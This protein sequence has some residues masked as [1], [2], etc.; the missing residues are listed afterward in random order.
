MH[1]SKLFATDLI[2]QRGLVLS[3]VVDEGRESIP[4]YKLL[5]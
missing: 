4:Y 2:M 3:K 5:D 1:N